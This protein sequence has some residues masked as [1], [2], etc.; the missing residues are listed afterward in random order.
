MVALLV[1]KK[2]SKNLLIFLAGQLCI[3]GFV[4][5]RAT[6]RIELSYTAEK[7]RYT[8]REAEAMSAQSEQEYYAL[9][10]SNRILACARERGFLP[11]PL[12]AQRPAP[13]DTEFV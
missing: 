7:L 10:A 2:I 1:M 5:Y 8:L 11:A 3:G 9:T 12:S 13:D 6:K 4:V